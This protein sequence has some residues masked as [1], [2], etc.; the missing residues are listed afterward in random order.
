MVV[1][2]CIIQLEIPMAQSLKEK[3]QVLRSLIRRIQNDFNVSIA[4]VDQQDAWQ[5][6]VLGVAC[7]SGDAAYAHGL[8]LKVVQRIQRSRLDLLLVD[9]VIEIL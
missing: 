2:L 8:L 5:Q 3:R 1:G 9:Y 7:V 4:E 6:A